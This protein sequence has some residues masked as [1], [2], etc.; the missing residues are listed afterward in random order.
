MRH[1]AARKLNVIDPKAKQGSR[2]DQD[3]LRI[4]QDMLPN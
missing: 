3:A 2:D 1:Y 4:T